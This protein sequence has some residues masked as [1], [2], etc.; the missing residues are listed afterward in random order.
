MECITKQILRQREKSNKLYIQNLE[1]RI[2]ITVKLAIVY[3]G[4]AARVHSLRSST[5]ISYSQDSLV[6]YAPISFSGHSL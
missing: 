1:F 6:P 5:K 4:K 2:Q 3:I